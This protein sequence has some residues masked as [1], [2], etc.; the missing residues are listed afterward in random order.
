MLDTHGVV[1]TSGLRSPSLLSATVSVRTVM[2]NWV[3]TSFYLVMQLRYRLRS[4]SRI[5][6]HRAN[7]YEGSSMNRR[8]PFR[9]SQGPIMSAPLFSKPLLVQ[10]ACALQGRRSRLKSLLSNGYSLSGSSLTAH[11][12]CSPIKASPRRCSLSLLQPFRLSCPV[13]DDVTHGTALCCVWCVF[14]S[15]NFCLYNMVQ[16]VNR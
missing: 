13:V 8:V 4:L 3:N 10:W 15:V 12:S 14:L 1:L 7:G 11:V 5:L 9:E 16:H 6:W 2:H